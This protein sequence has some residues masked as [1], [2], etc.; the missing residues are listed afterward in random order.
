MSYHKRSIAELRKFCA[1]RM[2]QDGA[3]L[4][5]ADL[6]S[7]LEHAD[8]QSRFP[9]FLELPPELRILVYEFSFDVMDDDFYKEFR[10]DSHA[11]WLQ[12]PPVASVCKLLRRESFPLFYSTA[13]LPISLSADSFGFDWDDSLE[14]FTKAPKSL[15]DVIKTITFDVSCV[16]HFGGSYQRDFCAWE[17]ELPTARTPYQITRLQAMPGWSQIRYV[18]LSEVIIEEIE[19]R[20]RETMDR[21]VSKQRGVGVGVKLQ[22]SDFQLFKTAFR[23]PTESMGRLLFE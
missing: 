8:E 22:L 11:L 3:G 18:R 15:L 12:P 17:I 4:R 20:L 16:R 6:V 1:D 2:L 19:Q 7:V 10:K 13:K 21:M 14:V 23:Y 9:R 5:K